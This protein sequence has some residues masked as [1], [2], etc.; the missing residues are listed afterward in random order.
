VVSGSGEHDYKGKTLKAQRVNGRWI[1]IPL[2]SKP[3]AK[4]LLPRFSIK[5]NSPKAISVPSYHPEGAIS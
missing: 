4:G 2:S 1:I 5:V 3:E